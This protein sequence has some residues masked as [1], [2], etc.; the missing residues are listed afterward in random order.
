MSFWEIFVPLFCALSAWSIS[1]EVLQIIA[2]YF[3]AK[4]QAARVEALQSRFEEMG[5]PGGNTAALDM[6][7]RILS[8]GQSS[9][10]YGLPYAPTTVSGVI[11][12][13]GQYV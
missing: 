4:R 3:L 9:P 5:G 8:E 2:G 10:Y 13:P 11:D 7:S 6:L 12:R 1:M